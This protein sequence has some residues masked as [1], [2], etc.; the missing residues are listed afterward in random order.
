MANFQTH[1]KVGIFVSGGAVLALDGVG[2][3]APQH[4]LALFGLGVL[5][6]LLPD[7]DANASSP[8][9]AI[10]GLLG[11]ALAFAWTLPMAGRHPPLELALAWAGLF[12]GTRFLLLLTFARFTVHRGIWHSW[13][14]VAFATLATVN[15]AHWVLHQSAK[16][17]WVAGL[18][19]GLGYFTH[20]C[21]DEI[22]S[23][24]IFNTRMKRSFGT[25][26]KPFSLADPAS[27]LRMAAAVA[28]LAWCVPAAEFTLV[29]GR[30]ELATWAGQTFGHLAVWSGAVVTT[31]RDWLQQQQM[32]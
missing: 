10:F 9:R 20:L 7:I 27:S 22:Y 13:L 31:M 6:S 8:V 32:M 1:L 17:A 21:L 12:V 24:D 26:L 30:V 19:V 4:T 28:A 14:A 2:L 16:P 29:P 18:M 15:L 23:V 3:V 11:A 5:G 25:A